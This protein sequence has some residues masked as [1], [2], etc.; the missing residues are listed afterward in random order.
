MWLKFGLP[1]ISDKIHIYTGDMKAWRINYISP[2]SL[3]GQVVSG[4]SIYLC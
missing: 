2:A 1:A 3:V 4:I